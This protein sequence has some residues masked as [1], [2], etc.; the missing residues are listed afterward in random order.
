[1]AYGIVRVS[2][3]VLP[4]EPLAEKTCVILRAFATPS[5]ATFSGTLVRAF[6]LRTNN[7]STA[8]LSQPSVVNQTLAPQKTWH[9][10][11]SN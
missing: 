5:K 7:A 1:M 8:V 3:V 2:I 9:A 4:W 6:C 10:K 11:G